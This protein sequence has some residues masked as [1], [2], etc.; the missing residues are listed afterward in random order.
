LNRRSKKQQEEKKKINDEKLKEAGARLKQLAEFV[1]FLNEK[2]FRN[3]HERKAFWRDVQDG[4]PVMEETLK[5]ILRRYG[6]K[7]ETI[8]ELD[9]RK[10]E[11]IEAMK[12]A[13]ADRIAAEKKVIEN[14][15][16]KK[17]E[18]NNDD[19]SKQG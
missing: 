4:K 3:R 15:A 1:Q 14:A 5:N 11:K 6:V 2:A 18:L 12:K 8:T 7:E 9:K 10:N 13:E 16:E 19:C 17:T